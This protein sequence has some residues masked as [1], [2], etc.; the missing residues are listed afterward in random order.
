MNAHNCTKSNEIESIKK[1][2]FGNGKRGLV[3]Y[4]TESFQK[5]DSLSKA[6]E[7]VQADVKVL[8][9]FQTQV[10]VTAQRDEIH[11]KKLE[12]LRQEKRTDKKWRT[13]LTITTILGLLG[14]V[15]TLLVLFIS[16][17]KKNMTQGVTDEEFQELWEAYKKEHNIRGIVMFEEDTIN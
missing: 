2:V 11:E 6:V 16:P 15:A 8:L 13:G 17:P 12:S 14:I 10:E 7:T 1:A 5:I 9:Q 4:M 3:S